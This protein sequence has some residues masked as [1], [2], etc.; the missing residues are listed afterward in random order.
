MYTRPTRMKKF[1]RELKDFGDLLLSCMPMI[2]GLAVFFG[3]ICA[4]VWWANVSSCERVCMINGNAWH[5]EPFGG[6][7]YCRDD[8]GLYNPRDSREDRSGR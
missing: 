6:G 3:V 7:C 4:G 5:Y 2:A 1:L 8:D